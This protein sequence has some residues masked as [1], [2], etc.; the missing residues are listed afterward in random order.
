MTPPGREIS[1][2]KPLTLVYI[3]GK[4][5]NTILRHE[6]VFEKR[7][8]KKGKEYVGYTGEKKFEK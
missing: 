3:R 5:Y 7:S 1:G 8:V 2:K 4:D 6:S